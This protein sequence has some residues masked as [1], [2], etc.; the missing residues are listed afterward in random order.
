MI[1]K[2]RV[3]GKKGLLWIVIGIIAGVAIYSMLYRQWETEQEKKAKSVYYSA[4]GIR[5][6]TG[7]TIHG[8]DVSSHQGNIYWPNVK[9]ME[10]E[11]IQMG[12]A[13]IKATEGLNDIDKQFVNNRRKAR[14]AGM[15]SGAYHFFLATKSGKEQAQNF[16]KQVPLQKGDLPPVVDIEN[17]YGVT[18]ELMRSRVK[19][20]LTLIEAHYGIKPMIY[21]YADFYERNLGKEF[22]DYPFWVAQ[23]LEQASPHISRQWT[24]WQYSE[25]GRV[26]G[27]TTSVDCNVFN[28]DSL[29]WQNILVK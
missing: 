5:I 23:Y 13:F 12:F 21:S 15:T 27:I 6:P 29:Q 22:E 17:L 10:I 20:W 18:P 9:A 16:I 7:Y 14:A 24:F 19:E 11:G 1:R 28:G 4:F 3:K 8:I 25:L 2:K 26:N